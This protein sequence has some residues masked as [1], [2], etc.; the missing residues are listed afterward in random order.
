MVWRLTARLGGC[1]AV[2]AVVVRFYAV[3]AVFVSTRSLRYLILVLEVLFRFC[4]WP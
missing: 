3:L 4:Q 1:D 2:N